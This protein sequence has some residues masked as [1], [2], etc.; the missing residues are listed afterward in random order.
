MR[1]QKLTELYLSSTLKVVEQLV[2]KHRADINNEHK[3]HTPL[4]CAIEGGH[5]GTVEQMVL[6]LGVRWSIGSIT[7]IIFG[8]LGTA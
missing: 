8:R 2:V 4:E 5:L 1:C 7:L 6:E 3:G